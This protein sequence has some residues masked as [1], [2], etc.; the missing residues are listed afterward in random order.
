MEVRGREGSH[1]GPLQAREEPPSPPVWSNASVW[2]FVDS[3]AVSKHQRNAGSQ[4]H[5][6]CPQLYWRAAAPVR[7]KIQSCALAPADAS[8]LNP[9]FIHPNTITRDCPHTLTGRRLQKANFVCTNA[10]LLSSAR[11]Q[12]RSTATGMG[13]RS[14]RSTNTMYMMAYKRTKPRGKIAAIH[15]DAHVVA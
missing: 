14:T 1:G 10:T 2:S 6:L 7:E 11:H 8:G 4:Q 9:S 5:L 13:R 15:I 12:G 3:C